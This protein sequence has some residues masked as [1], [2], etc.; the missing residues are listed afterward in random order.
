MAKSRIL[1][2]PDIASQ[3][4]FAS[5]HT[6]CVCNEPG[7]PVQ[8]HHI[9]ENPSNNDEANLS[10]LCLL[11]HD[12]T[13]IK[14]GFGRKLDA[15]LVTRYRDDWIRRITLR[16]AKADELAAFRIAGI[17]QETLTSDVPANRLP[18]SKDDV[19]AAYVNSLPTLLTKAY[20]IARPRW[21][22]GVTAEML[23]GTYDLIDLLVQIMVHLA[24]WFPE[25]HFDEKP[26]DSYFSGFVSNRFIWHRALAEPYGLG[27]GGTM[28]GLLVAGAVLSD[29][30]KT[31]GELVASLLSEREDFSF[32]AWQEAW[33]QVI[34]I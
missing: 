26:A 25:S 4:L 2:P 3:V 22:S 8:I 34:E 13:Q 17:S 33:E 24:S 30:T 29:M 9:D 11:C 1:I 27:T 21:D 16:R 32:V 14:G 6:C 28:V 7:R 20:A 15:N 10:V 5:D 23:Q 12:K 18:V 31:V 19:L